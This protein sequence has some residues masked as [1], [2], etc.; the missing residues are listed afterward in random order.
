MSQGKHGRGRQSGYEWDRMEV[1]VGMGA[2]E[3]LGMEDGERD[4][5]MAVAVAVR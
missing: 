2:E 4:M 3:R 5:E 1:D